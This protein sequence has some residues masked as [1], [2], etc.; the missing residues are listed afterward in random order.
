M[1]TDFID[2]KTLLITIDQDTHD[3]EFPKSGDLRLDVV[4]PNYKVNIGMDA[5]ADFSGL[6]NNIIEKDLSTKISGLTGL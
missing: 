3:E 6:F 2:D 4:F 5:N 1:S